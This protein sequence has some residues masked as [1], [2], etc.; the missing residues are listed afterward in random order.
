MTKIW[1]LKLFDLTRGKFFDIAVRKGEGRL[2][3]SETDNPQYRK[4]NK[5]EA[6]G[7][8][9]SDAYSSFISVCLDI[10]SLAL[11]LVYIV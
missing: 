1:R 4:I 10:G 11:P 7:V 2:S 6:Y 9:F 5:C 8:R 3:P